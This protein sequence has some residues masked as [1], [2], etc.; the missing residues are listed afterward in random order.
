SSRGAISSGYKFTVLSVVTGETHTYGNQW[1]RFNY[2]GKDGYII[3]N[4]DPLKQ[5]VTPAVAS[6]AL[7]KAGDQVE[8]LT[9]FGYTVRSEANSTSSSR[10]AIST[11]YKFTV[12]SVVTG[13]T[14]T[15][16]NQW[17]RFSYYGGNGYILADPNPAKQRVIAQS[18]VTTP[19][20]STPTTAPTT[21]TSG[22]TPTTATTSTTT[23][24]TTTA[25]PLP[26]PTPFPTQPEIVAG[27][28]VYTAAQWAEVLKAFPVSY[29][30]SLNKLHNAHPSW[31]FEAYQ[32]DFSL[33][34][35]VDVERRVPAR[36]LVP[37][38]SEYRDLSDNTVYDAGGWYTINRDALLFIMD[39]RNWLTDKYVFMFEKLS[40]VEN[41]PAEKRLQ[42]LFAGNADLLN[43]IPYVISASQ[44]HGVSPVFIGA[45]IRAEV[46]T[47]VGGVPTVTAPARGTLVIPPEELALLGLTVDP[48][49]RFYNVFNIGAYQGTNPQKN[50][51]LFAMGLAS[52]WEIQRY[53]LPWDS[54]Y[55]AIY[56]GITFIKE[57]YIGVGQ[58]TNYYMKYNLKYSAS[59]LPSRV[60]HQYMGNAFAP[61]TEASMQYTAN[62]RA[63]AM[64]EA[65]TFQVPVFQ[66]MPEWSYRNP[67]SRYTDTVPSQQP[68]GGDDDF[69]LTPPIPYANE[70]SV[71]TSNNNIY[72]VRTSPTLTS[73]QIG[74]VGAGDMVTVL[75][76]VTGDKAEGYTD[77]WYK[78]NYDG[79]IG[80]MIA[81]PSGQKIISEG[82]TTPTPA[83]TAV[84]T[85]VPTT[86]T[87]PTTTPTTTATPTPVP[88]TVK[89]TPVPTTVTPTPVPVKYGDANGDGTINIADITTIKY[90]LL[91]IQPLS[92]SAQKGADANK[93]GIVNIA[94]ITTIKYHLLGIISL[95]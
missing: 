61:G 8:V 79:A 59:E 45:R 37:N 69:E 38:W 86:T 21:S 58:N 85:P 32:H 48:A 34:Y 92:T 19:T 24:P 33:E 22:T 87:T 2:S 47:T 83:P 25:K 56:G 84:P 18:T 49:A 94:D 91:G 3:V 57:A 72:R 90:H 46:S 41:A 65:Y 50:G 10:G 15:Y 70:G 67:G 64:D 42:S 60:W 5:K 9:S 7:A 27:T 74:A 44:A 88:T 55:K 76:R 43:M 40:E 29:H 36:N 4:D 89:P 80:F 53:H 20:T 12:L 66:D 62:L 52:D 82:G 35:A 39:P 30:E 81:D 11:G 51:V 13:E 23:A 28:P 71:I 6:P 16:G 63:G 17:Y 1:Y 75:G 26:S 14:H 68:V 77:Q 73:T 93:D 95:E 31:R 54:L 78:I